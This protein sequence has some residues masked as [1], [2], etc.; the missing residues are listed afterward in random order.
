MARVVPVLGDKAFDEVIMGLSAEFLNLSFVFLIFL[1]GA[2][3][4]FLFSPLIPKLFISNVS[5][6]LR[7]NHRREVSRGGFF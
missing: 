7:G 4:V 6:S 2:V 5:L 3:I 1:P